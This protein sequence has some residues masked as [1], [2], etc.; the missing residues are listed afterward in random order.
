MTADSTTVPP[1]L[2]ATAGPLIDAHDVL[3]VDLDGVVYLGDRPIDGAAEALTA[4]RAGN[5]KPIFVTNN[6]SRPPSAVADQL[7]AMGVAAQPAEVMTSAI[8]AARELAVEFPV[9]T[10]VLVVGGQGVHDALVDVGL[11]PV[12]SA[13]EHPAAVLQGFAADV[14]WRSL[15]EAS[16]ALRAGAKWVATNTDL[17]LPSPRGPLPGN[18]SLVAALAAATGLTPHVVGKPQPALF[19]AALAASGAARP[20]VVGDRLDT[21]VAGARAAGLPS[22][23]VLSGVSSALDLICADPPFRPNQVGRDLRA[24]ALTHPSTDVS[25]D[26]A[27]CGVMR[28]SIVDAEVTIATADGSETADGTAT[29]DGLDGVR[30]LCALAWSADPGGRLADSRASYERAL[31]TLD[32]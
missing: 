20:L 15:A 24:L 16:I 3:L 6:A 27:S 12:D 5:V 17:T 25:N 32:A 23:L 2:V 1:G 31:S 9:G 8:A 4:A 10:P 21:D 22:M 30:A 26:V 28:A 29:P 18:G 13:E 11:K 19:K 7:V 14:G